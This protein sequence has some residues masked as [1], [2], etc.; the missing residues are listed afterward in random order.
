MD[1][2]LR[3]HALHGEEAAASADDAAPREFK[4]A[5]TGIQD[6]A[7]AR[8][9]AA[10]ARQ[11][12]SPHPDPTP[13]PVGSWPGSPPVSLRQ[14]TARQRATSTRQATV[15]PHPDE[16]GGEPRVPNGARLLKLCGSVFNFL[17][18]LFAERPG[19]VEKIL[20]GEDEVDVAAYLTAS[21]G[22]T[23][24]DAASASAPVAL[25]PGSG[26]TKTGGATPVHL[27]R[28]TERATTRSDGP[29]PPARFR[30]QC[31]EHAERTPERLVQLKTDPIGP[32]DDASAGVTNLKPASVQ[33]KA[34]KL[35]CGRTFK[36]GGRVLKIT[37]SRKNAEMMGTYVEI[38]ERFGRHAAFVK[39]GNGKKGS[40]SYC[41][42]YLAK[43]WRIAKQLPKLGSKKRKKAGISTTSQSMRPDTV[44]SMW[45]ET[46]GMKGKRM[47]V[48]NAAISCTLVAGGTPPKYEPYSSHTAASSVTLST[49]RM[50]RMSPTRTGFNLAT[51]P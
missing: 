40:H 30:C 10:V 21:G 45:Y 31:P 22:E 11:L 25:S 38:E 6:C 29:A 27:I 18:P 3:L 28:T 5:K 49:A 41:L 2:G 48:G 33:P 50:L 19:T 1:L 7:L 51:D 43:G 8:P 24:S 20:P 9:T 32:A 4:G 23:R 26:P 37:G 16:P 17:P 35:P 46:Q 47:S 39:D 36:E 14:Y 34:P 44:K 12:F 13:Y 15:G 42:F